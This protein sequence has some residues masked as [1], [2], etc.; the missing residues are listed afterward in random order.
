[1]RKLGSLMAH[2]ILVTIVS[3]M[4]GLMLFLSA[5]KLDRRVLG[6]LLG[7][8]GSLTIL[9]LL[10]MGVR[11]VPK[12]GAVFERSHVPAQVRAGH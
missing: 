6:L 7:L 4:F 11:L 3:F 8:F 9:L 10:T 12:N 1:M 5:R 2:C